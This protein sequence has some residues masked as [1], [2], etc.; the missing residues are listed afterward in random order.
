MVVATLHVGRERILARMAAR[1]VTAVVTKGDGFGE[2][3]IQAERSRDGNGDL[4]HFK[5]VRQACS[6]VILG[7]DEDLRFPRQSAERGCVKNSVA[8]ALEARTKR[9]GLFGG[10][11]VA[12]TEGTRRMWCKKIRLVGLARVAGH[13]IQTS[14]AGPRIS[15]G[16]ANVAVARMAVHGGC[17]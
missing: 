1:T 13:Q 4:G 3:H 6:L 17:P 10:V 8:I 11:A 15:M 16:K 5:C 9:I 12:C 14:G 7:E 2:C